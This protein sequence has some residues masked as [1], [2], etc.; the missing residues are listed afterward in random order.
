[1]NCFCP[2]AAAWSAG[3]WFSCWMIATGSY[4]SVQW[5]IVCFS[6]YCRLKHWLPLAFFPYASI[7]LW[8]GQSAWCMPCGTKCQMSPLHC[9]SICQIWPIYSGF[10]SDAVLRAI[11]AREHVDTI[12]NLT[13]SLYGKHLTKHLKTLPGL[14]PHRVVAVYSCDPKTWQNLSSTQCLL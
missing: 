13:F 5:L 14:E 10:T 2:P 1:M 3:F 4:F 11:I 8:W 12:Y 7:R 9:W 6:V